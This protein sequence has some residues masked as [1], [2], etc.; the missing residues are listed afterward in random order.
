MA[1]RLNQ[2]SSHLA[3]SPTPRVQ[4]GVKNPED[5]VIVK[6]LRTPITRAKK[7]GFKDTTADYLLGSIFKGLIERTKIDPALVEDICVGNVCP[8]GGGATLARMAALYAG[9]PNTT[10]VQT[11]N[12][13]CSSGLQAVVHIAHQ[14]QAGMIEIGIGAGVESMTSFYGP[15]YRMT[16]DTVSPEVLAVQEAADCLTPMGFTS[17]NVAADFGITRQQQDEFAA[18]SHHKAVK[19]QK[20]GLFDEEI[21][22]VKTTQKDKDGSVTEVIV[23]RDD[24]VRPGTTPQTLSKLKPVFDKNGSTT[25][26]NA[27]Q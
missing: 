8:P 21:Y 19:A 13:Q 26:G 1:A 18:L 4:I 7:G 9:F 11:V 16:K 17:E 2:V 27:S 15:G 6:A 23:S 24:G 12:R 20:E 10:S 25:A 5:V 22:P 3:G 14:I